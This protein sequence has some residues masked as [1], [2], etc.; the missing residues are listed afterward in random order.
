M[1]EV[2]PTILQRPTLLIT[3]PRGWELEARQELRRLL[4]GVQVKSLFIPG[5]LMAV[6]EGELQ[7]ALGALADADTETVGR[8]TPVQLRVEIGPERR[9]LGAM[10][11]AA[12]RLPPPERERSF[13]V[14]CN[15]RGEHEFT[16]RDVE[17]ALADVFVTPEGPP[18]DLEQPEQ[19]LSAEIFQDL[20]FMGMNPAEHLLHKQLRRMRRWAPGERPISRAELKLREAIDEFGLELPADGRALDLGAAPGGWTRVLAERVAEVV[21]VDPADLDKR[22]TGLANVTHI[23]SRAEE[24]DAERLGRFDVLTN[25][26]NLEPEDSARLMCAVAELLTPGA[27]AVMTI[28]FVTRHRRRH[29]REAARI[30]EDCY[31]DIRVGRMPHNARETTAVMRRR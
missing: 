1:A 12:G 10:Q 18:V 22:V 4:P 2:T 25:D 6:P 8:V 24:L 19:V 7:E 15:R 9:W 16:S 31:R 23:R 26:M 29:V 13:R 30:L 21:A 5:N 28:K 27:V 3:A 20:A 11:E 14:A 17:L